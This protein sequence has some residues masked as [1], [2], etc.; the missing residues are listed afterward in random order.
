MK[1]LFDIHS[2]ISD[3]KKLELFQHKQMSSDSQIFYYTIQ[4]TIKIIDP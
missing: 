2:L 1:S 4:I 3:F